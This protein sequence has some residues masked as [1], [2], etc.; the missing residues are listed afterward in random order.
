MAHAQISEQ[1]GIQPDEARCARCGAKLG[2]TPRGRLRRG[3]RFCSARCQQAAIREARAAARRELEL[4]LLQLERMG[5]AVEP[6]RIVRRSL[7]TLGVLRRDR[8]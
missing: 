6:A 5:G 1:Q 3:K 7:Q 4:A 2:L 8:D